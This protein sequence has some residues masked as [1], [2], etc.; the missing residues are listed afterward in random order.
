MKI[1]I[2][3]M[4]RLGSVTA[5]IA[6]EN[7]QEAEDYCAEHAGEGLSFWTVEC[8]FI[9]AHRYVINP[10]VTGIRPEDMIGGKIFSIPKWGWY[11]IAPEPKDK[12]LE[13]FEYDFGAPQK[14]LFDGLPSHDNRGRMIAYGL[15][16]NCPKC[17]PQC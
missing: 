6:F 4:S 16:C 10:A 13:N 7:K 1:Y 17:S 14:C 9:P 8:E 11:G 2:V 15:S 5:K 12:R 3:M